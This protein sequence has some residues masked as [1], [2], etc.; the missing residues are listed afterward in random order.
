[1]L[2]LLSLNFLKSLAAYA[3]LLF[4]DFSSA[5][6]AF[7]PQIL[8]EDEAEKKKLEE[9]EPFFN[10]TILLLPLHLVTC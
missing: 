8:L 9:L 3:R 4:I 5:W 2:M 7:L 10:Q 1:M 6:N